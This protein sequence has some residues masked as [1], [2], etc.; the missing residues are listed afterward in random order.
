[1]NE[2]K[3]DKQFIYNRESFLSSLFSDVVTFGTLIS[4]MFLNVNYWGGHW[5]VTIPILFMWFMWV[6]GKGSK[7]LHVFYSVDEAIKYLETQRGDKWVITKLLWTKQS[8]HSL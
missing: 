3:P 7:R 1:M 5:Y 4:L 2:N 8:W 6:V